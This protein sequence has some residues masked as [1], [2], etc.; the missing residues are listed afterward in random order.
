MRRGA[1]LLCLWVTGQAGVFAFRQPDLAGAPLGPYDV[2]TQVPTSAPAEV[3]A[4]VRKGL[5]Q[6][7]GPRLSAVQI[8]FHPATGRPHNLFS[9]QERLSGPSS[10]SAET[11]ARDFLASH[12]SLFSL[13]QDEIAEARVVDQYVHP[14]GQSRHLVFQQRCANL[15]VFQARLSFAVDAQGRVIQVAGDYYPGLKLTGAVRLSALEAVQWAA[16]YCDHGQPRGGPVLPKS[17]LKL[18]VLSTEQGVDRRT[19]FA[20]GPFRDPVTAHLV[21]M[22]VGSEGIPAWEMTLHLN[23][24]ECHHVLVDARNGSLL[25]RTNLYKFA[26]PAGLVFT[27]HPDAGP[28]Q[29]VS[30]AGDPIASPAGWCDATSTTQGNNVVAREDL[31]GDN[32]TPGL[33][34]FAA[35]Q[36]FLFPF[37]NGWADQHTTSSAVADAMAVVTNVFY[38]CNWYHDYLY[39]L[40]FN[41]NSGNFQ[42]DN[43]GRGG[44]GRDPVHADAMDG[45]GPNM[46]NFLTLPDGDPAG[47]YGGH[48]R[49]QISPFRP[50]PPLY[51]LYRDGDLDGDIVLHE[52]THGMTARM[53]GGPSNVLALDTLQAAAMAEG[54]S[55]FF[56]CS[57]FNDP[58]V[59]EY[60]TGNR[61]RGVRHGAYNAHPWTFGWVGNT[62]DITTQ[63]LPAGGPFT[64]LYLPEE[65]NDG[66]IW[67]AALWAL[68]TEIASPRTTDFLVVEALR[69]T[70][71]HPTMLDARDAILLADALKIQGKYRTAIWRAFARRGMGWSAET[72][73]GTKAALVFQA[74]DWPP[75]LGGS[76]TTATV[77]F[78]DNVE[79]SRAGWVV[80]HSTSAASVAFHV[81]RHR[82]ASAI[83]SWY[84]GEEGA[85]NYDTGF[86]EWST[87]E[88]PPIA[89]A[90]G[91]GYLLEFKHRRSGED[92][93]RWDAAPFYFDVAIIYVHPA[94]TNEY[95][96]VGFAFR[97]TS[98]WETCHIDLSRFAG[99]T[100]RIGFYFDTWD[101]YNNA[102]EGWY[103]DDVRVLQTRTV[104]TPPTA[105]RPWWAGYR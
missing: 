3:R 101:Q 57:V 18:A 22:A 14:D 92:A 13:A 6:L 81:T 25:Y 19:Q 63:T 39:A 7:A 69:Y 42:Q 11:I 99:R 41:E 87:L 96:Q 28:R 95:H 100:V 89:L 84:F 93:I 62:Y 38:F 49:L 43:F 36:R 105:A 5:A 21:V 9:L 1:I 26:Q 12:Q 68:R 104:N 46:A 60:V 75:P 30:F 80:R 2:R 37:T 35:D 34:P 50:Q 59:G 97:N 24:L 54:W 27:E 102:F 4:E 56:P 79:T 90:A 76:F 58:V 45:G 83:R 33:A 74:F 32:G 8:R 70:P 103:I 78:S 71:I 65:H 61:T 86:R 10:R 98:G 40:G 16:A 88:T 51:S 72:E 20:S 15:D 55:D 66:E 82:S 31:D 52:L 85:W 64:T 77:V 17:S 47:P 67:A 91:S 44:Q 94:G 29:T 53:V 48:S 73:A 23:A